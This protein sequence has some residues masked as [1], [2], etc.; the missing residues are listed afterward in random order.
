MAQLTHFL[1]SLVILIYQIHKELLHKLTN[2]PTLH[3]IFLFNL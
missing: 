2:S 3:P 1:T